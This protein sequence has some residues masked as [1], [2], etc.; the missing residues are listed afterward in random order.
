MMELINMNDVSHEAIHNRLRLRSPIQI[1]PLSGFPGISVVV[2][3]SLE[4]VRSALD[5][6]RGSAQ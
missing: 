6:G 3:P 2:P 5:T 4:G 1:P